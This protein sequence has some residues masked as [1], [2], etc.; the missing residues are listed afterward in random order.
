MC[1]GRTDLLVMPYRRLALAATIVVATLTSAP[2]A[3][4]ATDT[5]TTIRTIAT[6]AAALVAEEQALLELTDPS[7]GTSEAELV[8]IEA[9]LASV[10]VRSASL[11]DQLERLGVDLTEAVRSTMVRL[12]DGDDLTTAQRRSAAPPAV[13]Y[14]A[15]V[16][17]LLRIA[18][19]P[20]TVAPVPGRSNS[21][22]LGLLAV[23]AISLLA[24]GAAALGNSLRRKP[25]T[26]ELVALAWSDG[27]TGLANRRR[28]DLD[29]A[30]SSRHASATA[31]IMLDVD[32]F[33]KVN[34]TYGHER[35][36]DVLRRVGALLADHVRYDD[37]VYRYGGEEFCILLPGAT[38][39]EARAVADRV[40]VAARKI[41]LPDGAHITVSIGVA[42]TST[43]DVV[44]AVESADQALFTAKQRGRD[45]AVTADGR[46]LT[47]A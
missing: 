40:V 8:A 39:A 4:A 46:S 2:T 35:G 30:S 23:A 25:A 10:D 21:P 16:E 1:S 19:T 27:L 47:V 9:Q 13:V 17:D 20:A 43:G 5:E 34:E 6:E 36:D 22:A 26:D 24:L 7:A 18:A 11:L 15:A 42:D 31:V 12:P 32:H 33:K 3:H 41:E 45:R 44:T 29:I 37:V 14:A 38:A 28:L